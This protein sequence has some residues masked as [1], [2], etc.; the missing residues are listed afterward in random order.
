MTFKGRIL[1]APPMLKHF[2]AENKYEI[3]PKIG[4]F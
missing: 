2:S 1:L 3:R 4:V